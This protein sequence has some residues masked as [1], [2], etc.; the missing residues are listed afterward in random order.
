MNVEF[1]VGSPTTANFSNLTDTSGNPI[2]SDNPDT[3]FGSI[4]DFAGSSRVVKASPSELSYLFGTSTQATPK[5]NVRP[6][7]KIK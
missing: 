6:A 5:G 7:H 1:Q 4:G 2:A 3:S